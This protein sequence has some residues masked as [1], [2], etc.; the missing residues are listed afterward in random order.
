MA[1]KKSEWEPMGL[2]RFGHLED[3]I[4]RFVEAFKAIRKENA[5][6]RDENAKMKNELEQL[7]LTEAGRTESMA[8]LQQ[9]RQELRDRV[10]NALTLLAALEER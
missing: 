2:E 10:E 7:Q 9:E 3:K 5:T 8:Q 1:D 4:F 6:L